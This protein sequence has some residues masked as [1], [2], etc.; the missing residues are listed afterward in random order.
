MRDAKRRSGRII[1]ALRVLSALAALA[2][3]AGCGAAE[4][5]ADGQ[6]GAAAQSRMVALGDA[7]SRR[8]GV[9]RLESVVALSG[10]GVGGLSGLWV[11]PDSARFA[12]VADDGRVFAGRLTRDGDGRLTGAADLRGGPL[13]PP[14]FGGVGKRDNDAEE[15]VRLPD[16]GWL[17]SFE[18]N[19]RLLR[20]G[21]DFGASGV[22]VEIPAPPGLKDAP[23]NGGVEALAAWPDASILA[24]E[25]GADGA[26]A[27]RGWFAPS[28]PDSPSAWRPFVYRPAPGHRP[29]GAAAL[30]NGDALALE[31]RASLLGG[32]S[33][34]VV[35][36][37]RSAFADAKPGAVVEG[38]ELARLTPPGPSDNFEGVAAVRRADGDIDVYL[39]SDDNFSPLQSTLLVHFVLP[40]RRLRA[41]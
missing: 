25:E 20:F 30:P 8:V 34:R 41:P 13:S 1:G 4:T 24:L 38:E 12:A 9:L 14:G 31:R 33:V 32:F 17:V 36:L 21:E 26:A 11:S 10:G 29:S 3:T 2:G 28:P 15:L 27:T 37:R 5:P 39:L 19:H 22:P 35:L 23:D 7:A 16:G 18:R 40:Q 6:N